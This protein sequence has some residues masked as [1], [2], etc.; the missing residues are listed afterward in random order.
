MRATFALAIIGIFTTLP[1]N[2]AIG[3][4]TTV[5]EDLGVVSFEFEAVDQ[6]NRAYR[7]PRNQSGQ[8]QISIMWQQ[9]KDKVKTIADEKCK[10]RSTAVKKCE[11][12]SPSSPDLNKDS[13]GQYNL[14]CNGKANNSSAAKIIVEAGLSCRC[15]IQQPAPQP[16]KTAVFE[17]F[18]MDP[19]FAV[20]E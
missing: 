11:N 8:Y 18:T 14:I 13:D 4:S 1:I 7:C 6:Q 9:N 20:T 19:I 16:V 15:T 12:N 5:I 17:N 2:Y 3:Q 10:A